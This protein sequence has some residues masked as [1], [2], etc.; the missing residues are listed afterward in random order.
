MNIA[1]LIPTLTTGGAER[2]ATTIGKHFFDNGNNVYYFLFS[3]SGKCFYDVKGTIV[4]THITYPFTQGSCKDN[5]RELFFAAKSLKKLKQVYAIDV[6]ISFMEAWNIINICSRCKDK[7]IV[8]VRTVLSKR[9]EFGGFLYDPK[10]I[11]TLYNKA[12]IIVAVSE[13]VKEDLINEYNIKRKKAVVI[14]N[15]SI[16]H[17]D[18]NFNIIDWKYGDNTVLCV[19]RLDPVKQFHH[20]IRA[21]KYVVERKTSA[22]LVIVGEGRQMNYLKS[23]CKECGLERN[24]SFEGAQTN[25][26]YYLKNAK[27]FVMSSKVEGFPNAMV[28]AMAFGLPVISTDSPGGC[29][30]IIGKND[31]EKVKEIKYCEYGVLTPYINCSEEEDNDIEKKEEKLGKAINSIISDQKYYN[32]YVKK[33]KDRALCYNEE[34]IMNKWDELVRY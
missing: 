7:I 15:P 10:V 33:S 18:T 20:V 27:C 9:N 22:H 17:E 1:I 16:R 25:I 3:N 21:F 31:G 24:V 12:D 14:S 13:G 29:G 6:S 30:E 34:N 11:K 4:K 5:I 32:L 26:G 2:A 28:E 23:V 19:G 8:S